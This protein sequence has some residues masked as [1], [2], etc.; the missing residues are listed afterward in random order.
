VTSILNKTREELEDDLPFDPRPLASTQRVAEMVDEF[1]DWFTKSNGQPELIEEIF[2]Q[3]LEDHCG[4]HE[5]K[6]REQYAQAFMWQLG[7]HA[8]ES[9]GCPCEMILAHDEHALAERV[10]NLMGWIIGKLQREQN[11][12]VFD[13]AC[14]IVR[15]KVGLYLAETAMMFQN[16]MRPL[17]LDIIHRKHGEMD[18]VA[19]VAH[20]L[21][22][23][24]KPTSIRGFAAELE[25]A[26]RSFN[27]KPE[28]GANQQAWLTEWALKI[29][30]TID[31][32][33]HSDYFKW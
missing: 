10:V 31:V 28:K 19:M 27:I 1:C 11:A 15:R 18:S 6:T 26:L 3:I 16:R 8:W 2:E 12:D 17:V 22:A 13:F 24:S 21:L 20:N 4:K 23:R 9:R 32:M 30:A 5:P 33:G 7:Q 25:A 14:N 29:W